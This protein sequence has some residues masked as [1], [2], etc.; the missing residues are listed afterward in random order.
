MKPSPSS[1]H[2]YLSSIAFV[3][4]LNGCN[5]L[6]STFEIT[7][8]MAG[9]KKQAQPRGKLLPITKNLLYKILQACNYICLLEYDLILYTAMFLVSFYACLGASEFLETKSN[10]DMQHSN[11]KIVEDNGSK[12]VIIKLETYKHSKESRK[13]KLQQTNHK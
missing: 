11:V 4:K 2:T 12:S 9:V 1:I 10:H 8:L 3:L 5:D 6:T 7:K 13:I